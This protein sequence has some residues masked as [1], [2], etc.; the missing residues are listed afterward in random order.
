M[1]N[2]AKRASKS[3][4][5][6]VICTFGQFKPLSQFSRRHLGKDKPPRRTG[7]RERLSIL[8]GSQ[9][10][11]TAEGFF[12]GGNATAAF[13][14]VARVLDQS[15]VFFRLVPMKA[16]RSQHTQVMRMIFEIRAGL[17]EQF[18]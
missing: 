18:S 17:H 5:R 1:R 3:P 13:A 2:F 15:F 14:D 11:R 10:N 6:S 4:F 12:F 7:Q 9:E 16:L 8:P